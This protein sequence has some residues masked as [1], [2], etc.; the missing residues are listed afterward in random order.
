MVAAGAVALALVATPFAAQRIFD[1]DGAHLATRFAVTAAAVL[2]AVTAGDAAFRSRAS[3]RWGW[4]L[5][6]FTAACWSVS[7]LLAAYAEMAR[8]RALPVPSPADVPAAVAVLSAALAVLSL[9]GAV[10][11]STARMRALLDGL[12]IASALLFVAWMSVLGDLQLGSGG[13]PE[14]ALALG[15]PLGDVAVLALLLV[16]STRLRLTRPWV[17]LMA[18]FGLHTISHAAFAY[19]E[20][21]GASDPG[22]ETVSWIA[23]TLLIAVAA[24]PGDATFER[25]SA[26]P[27]AGSAADVLVPMIPLALCLVFAARRLTQGPL[28]MFLLTNAG[29]IVVLLVARQLLAQVEYL[30]LYRQLEASVLH[31]VD[32][33]TVVAPDGRI[34]QQ[35]GP[36][37]RILGHRAGDLVGTLFGDLIHPN[38]RQDVVNFLKKAPAPPAPP[39]ALEL[40]LKRGDGRWTLTQTT[41]SDL[42]RHPDV[43]GYLLSSRDVGGR[44]P[45]DDQLDVSALQDPLTGLGNRVLFLDRLRS[46]VEKLAASPELLTVVLIDVDGF[47][48]LNDT[49]GHA[50]GDLLLI[51]VATRIKAVSRKG[52]TLARVGADEFGILL[53]RWDQPP[54][55]STADRTLAR[56]REPFALHGREIPISACAGVANGDIAAL[57]AESLLRSAD[58]ALGQAKAE[59]KSNIS[60]FRQDMQ[61]TARRRME[62]ESDLRRALEQDELV[63]YFQPIVDLPSGRIAGAEALMRWNQGGRGMTAPSEFLAVAEES[64]LV[65]SLGRWAL[66]E[67]CRQAHISQTSYATHPPF[68]VSVNLSGRQVMHPHLL[69]EVYNALRKTD[70]EPS[71][72]VLEIT[73]NALADESQDLLETVNSLKR[74]GVQLAIDDFGTGSSSLSRL[75]SFPVDKIK[76]DRPFIADI[77]S[78]EDEAPLLAAIVAMAHSLGVTTVAEGV[79]TVEQLAFLWQQG[80]ESAQ[81]FGVYKPVPADELGQLLGGHLL[82]LEAIPLRPPSED[83]QSY[84]DVISAVARADAPLDEVTG[85]LLS[86]LVRISGAEAAF[87][88]QDDTSHVVERIR[89]S[90]AASGSS[91][92]VHQG[93]VLSLSGSP[94]DEARRSGAYIEGDLASRYPAHDLAKV[95]RAASHLGVPVVTPEG[96]TFGTLCLSS[97]RAHAIT[98]DVEQLV[99]LLARLLGNHPEARAAFPVL[100]S[101]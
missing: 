65:I 58:L 84:M 89:C 78:A 2:A 27:R 23:G 87:L 24:L 83:K 96:S 45:L 94:S 73:E 9:L 38:G 80:C 55:M 41:V 39:A 59:G 77:R 53:E 1:P 28:D 13:V 14:R 30:T 60:V 16:S 37:E 61:T 15:Y 3:F 64:D 29:V 34:L 33:L 22:L 8:G 66:M 71:S 49:L 19:L 5:L 70:L 31:G 6:A 69:G 40:M 36:S 43:G 68:Y 11:P 46:A 20:V 25:R 75:R 98:N 10:L 74:L 4:A 47:S 62:V 90:V 88:T 12:L 92:D 42:R 86:Q 72:L 100:T 17:F 32:I 44:K 48:E 63:L 91:L 97:S 95:V 93:M 57:T 67:A 52:D 7:N 76:I 18:G 101:A 54:P 82:M 85:P 56:L 26:A 21:A 35:T 79:E 50:A 51:E 81:G 99:E